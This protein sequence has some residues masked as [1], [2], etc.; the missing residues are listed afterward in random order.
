LLKNANPDAILA[1][2]YARIT[3]NDKIISRIDQVELGQYIEIV[4]QNGQLGGKVD[5]KESRDV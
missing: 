2:G 4:L 5:M 3:S 1:K